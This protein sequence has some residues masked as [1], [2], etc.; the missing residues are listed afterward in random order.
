MHPGVNHRLLLGAG[1]TCA[2]EQRR[3]VH[4]KLSCQCRFTSRSEHKVVRRH[5][6]RVGTRGRLP[7]AR[8]IAPRVPHADLPRDSHVVPSEPV[9][10]DTR[11]ASAIPSSLRR[12][13]RV[14]SRG[15]I[16]AAR[17]LTTL[18]ASKTQL[19]EHPHNE[20]TGCITPTPCCVGCRA[21]VGGRSGRGS[22]DRDSAAPGRPQGRPPSA[23]GR[24]PSAHRGRGARLLARLQRVSG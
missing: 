23:R 3:E 21:H 4:K 6:R 11:N 22:M 10:A 15:T 13:R 14:R 24:E 17:P 12:S 19:Q 18:T 8:W 20:Q 16:L 9:S 5:I 2:R 7:R 1:T